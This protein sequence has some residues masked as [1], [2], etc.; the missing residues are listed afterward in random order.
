[1]VIKKLILFALLFTGTIFLT[2]CAGF[3]I[4]HPGGAGHTTPAGVGLGFISGDVTY[5]NL[6][7]GHTQVRFD[8]DDFEILK[9][10]TAEATSTNILGFFSSGDN[11]YGNLHRQAIAIGADD[12]IN[13]KVDTRAR[14]ILGPLYTQSTVILT[15]TAI[16][17]K[18]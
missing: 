15:G 6:I 4:T 9:T 11:G 12:V 8:T 17:W 7:N 14:R 3:A 2:G 18:K 1:M 16:R 13:V 5:P 10:V